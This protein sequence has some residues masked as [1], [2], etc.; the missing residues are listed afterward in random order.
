MSFAHIHLL[1][2]HVPTVGFSI[3]L[4]LFMVALA[5]R[6]HELQRA[7]LVI[8]FLTAALTIATYVS[9]NDAYEALKE[10]PGLSEPLMKAHESAALIAFILMQA[11]GFFSWVGLWVSAR[12]HRIA[13][14]NLGVVLVLAIVTFGFMARAANIGGE[15]RH[16]EIQTAPAFST[17]ASVP[18]LAVSWTV[19][20][21]NHS[22]GM[23]HR[24]NRSLY[25]TVHAF[26]S[27]LDAGLA[28]ARLRE[29]HNLV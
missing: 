19:F 14:W 7:G 23:A 8:F 20:V 1:L 6:N 21:E 25:R 22:L 28:N 3:G 17:D 27:G 15:I 10:T 4:A 9:G 13:N 18:T 16:P 26:R 24:G 12:S 2:N 29:K 11:A 5:G